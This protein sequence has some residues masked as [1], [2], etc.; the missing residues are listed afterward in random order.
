WFTG[1][2]LARDYTRVHGRRA[3]GA[4]NAAPRS[5]GRRCASH[6]PS[7]RRGT[8]TEPPGPPAPLGP[9]DRTDPAPEALCPAVGPGPR[10][11]RDRDHGTGSGDAAWQPADQGLRADRRPTARRHDLGR[12][13]AHLALGVGGDAGRP[14]EGPVPPGLGRGER[15]RARRARRRSPRCALR[16]M[17]TYSSSFDGAADGLG[18][19]LDAFGRGPDAR[20]T[21]IPSGGGVPPWLAGMLNY[22]SRCGTELTFGPIEGEDRDRRGCARRRSRFAPS[23]LRRSPGRGSPSRRRTGRS[24]TGSTAAGRTSIRPTA[25][26]TSNARL[27]ENPQLRSM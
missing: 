12:P 11:R 15:R 19:V 24:A 22:C 9:G 17:A 1:R 20:S 13:R 27:A 10:P 2:S 4:G 18:E 6:R 16:L 8:A 7:V 14:D 25:T 26:G 23:Y 5:A 3:L 21:A